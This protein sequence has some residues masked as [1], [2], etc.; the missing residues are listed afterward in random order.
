MVCER[1]S[2][3]GNK[4]ALAVCAKRRSLFLPYNQPETPES[5]NAPD[6]FERNALQDFETKKL[7]DSSNVEKIGGSY[8]FR[9]IAPL[10]VEEACLQCHDKQGYKVGDIRGAISVSV[11]MDHTLN[12]IASDRKYMIY[13]S[14]ITIT[15]LITVLFMTTKR[16][17]ISPINKIRTLMFNFAKTAI[18]MSPCSR[19]M[20]NLR[21]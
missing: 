21:I 1:K 18:P 4:A 20:T 3:N 8:Y 9:Y 5:E 13:G 17:V 12:V 16:L 7:K 11:P 6:D 15:V 19:Q 14:I 2:G 10:Y